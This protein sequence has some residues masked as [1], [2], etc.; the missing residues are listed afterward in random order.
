MIGILNSEIS[1]RLRIV[2]RLYC[3]GFPTTLRGATTSLFTRGDTDSVASSYAPT[4]ASYMVEENI[5]H[6]A[7]LADARLESA[8]QFR[9]KALNL[10]HRVSELK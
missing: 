10:K 4:A 6:A 5:S 1:A 9:L 7:T 3:A 2:S 8:L